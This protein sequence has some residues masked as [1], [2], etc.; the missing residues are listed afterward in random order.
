MF[1]RPALV[2]RY[3]VTA[4]VLGLL[5]SLTG[6][7]WTGARQP[8]PAHGPARTTLVPSAAG[9]ET[10]LAGYAIQSSAKVGDSPAAISS[11]GYPATGWYPASPRSTVL[12]A[13][14]ADGVYADPFYSTNQQKIPKADFQVPCGTARTSPSR[15]PR[16]TF[17]D[18]SG[19]ISAADVYLKAPLPEGRG[20][21]ALQG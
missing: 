11:P 4:L 21:V 13:L 7:T 17:L 12:A 14:L 16:R 20:C 5:G 1:P 18:F 10:P 3:A 9:A 8:A 19:V 15:T 2:R 6:G